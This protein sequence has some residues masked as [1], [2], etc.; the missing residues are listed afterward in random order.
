MTGG[1]G[2]TLIGP[3]IVL[4]AAHCGPYLGKT[5]K[6]GGT[7]YE[8]TDQR[9]HPNYNATSI[10]H[11]YD[12]SLLLLASSATSSTTTSSGARVTLNTDAATAS[13]EG[14][15]LTALTGLVAAT[16]PEGETTF[17]TTT[18]RKGSCNDDTGGPIIVIRNGMEHVQVGVVVS[19]GTTNSSECGDRPPAEFPVIYGRVSEVIPWIQSVA[20]DVWGGTSSVNGLVCNARS[21]SNTS[22]VAR[23]GTVS[24]SAARRTMASPSAAR[25][26]AVP[27]TRRLVATTPTRRPVATTPTQRPVS[28]A[29]QRPAT[30]STRRPVDSLSARPVASRP[31]V[32][33]P[34]GRPM[35]SPSAR[36]MAATVLP[37][38]GPTRAPGSPSKGPITSTS[39]APVLPTSR[40]PVLPTSRAPVLPTRAPV[41]PTRAPV[42]PTRAPVT[43][44]PVTPT[45]D[46]LL[47]ELRS[48]IAPTDVDLLKFRTPTSPQARALA[49]LKSDPINLRQGR[50][51]RTVLERYVLAVLYFSTSGPNWQL[52]SDIPYLSGTSA[53]TWNNGIDL[54]GS[55]REFGVYCDKRTVDRLIVPSSNLNGTFPWELVLLTNLVAAGLDYNNISGSIPSRIHEL[56][57]LEHFVVSGNSLSGSIPARTNEL[58]RLKVFRA[59]WNS[60]SGLLTTFSPAITEINLSYNTLIGSIPSTFGTNMPTL[61]Y[62]DISGNQLTGPIP[63]FLCLTKLK[64]FRAE[65]NSLSGLLTT[66]SPAIV[67]INLNYNELIGSIPTTFGTNMPNL[68]Y[69]DISDNRLTGTIPSFSGLTKL[70]VFRAEWNFLSGPLI[71]TFSPSITQI[72]LHNNAL[73]GSIPTSF[74]INMPNLEYLDISFNQLTGTIPSFLDLTKLKVFWA[75][76]NALSGLPATF[77]PAITQIYLHNNALIGSIPTTFGTNMTNLEIIE[78]H[79][80]Q[81]TGTIPSFLGLLKLR[82]FRAHTNSLTGLPATFSPA[83]NNINLS[84]NALIGSIPTTFGANMPNLQVL[85]ISDNNLNGTVPSSLGLIPDLG[86]FGFYKNS[87]TGSVD[88]FLC[89]AGRTRDLEAD[90][91][92]VTCTCCNSCHVDDDDGETQDT[93][94][95][96]FV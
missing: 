41:L 61:E 94:P 32:P 59:D 49:W 72:N 42:L 73:I 2:G 15:A 44:P 43:L 77:T 52:L 8:V 78:I 63:S 54:A 51:T 80:N 69:L 13:Y 70:N 76:W 37:T 83:I 64:V 12:F 11:E 39:R 74:G 18:T 27:T 34:S 58:T 92:E 6:I 91:R 3:H 57:K 89:T 30:T 1:C 28:T 20:C 84:K 85:D 45:G 14:R 5:V 96:I 17:P 88:S 56:T 23:D 21:T 47:D 25:R 4:S 24:T 36:P 26:M 48:F 22:P 75:E 29:T 87:F 86:Y 31:M 9:R 81:L 46:P 90:C 7:L 16:K 40:A 53:C 60:L 50:S 82:T 66:F 95:T 62:L 67:E 93:V 10:N 33:A 71:T 79:N 55:T 35:A 19:W 68:E 38:R 65:W